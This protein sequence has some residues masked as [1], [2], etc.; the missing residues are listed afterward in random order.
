MI[1][2]KAYVNKSQNQLQALNEI[3]D[4][5]V[6]VNND[7]QNKLQDLIYESKD[8]KQTIEKLK[9]EIEAK[10]KLIEQLISD[11]NIKSDAIVKYENN[12][13]E[14]M[15]KTKDNTIQLRII[16][17]KNER[18]KKIVQ[19]QSKELERIRSEN[20]KLEFDKIAES[21]DF[22]QERMELKKTIGIAEKSISH[23]TKEKHLLELKNNLLQKK[24][25]K[26]ESKTSSKETQ[27]K[28]CY[29]TNC[30]SES[31]IVEIN[32]LLK[33]KQKEIVHA[34]KY[35][36][37][38][39]EE[40]KKMQGKHKIIQMESSELKKRLEENI[41][42]IEKLEK[43]KNNYMKENEDLKKRR[44]QATSEITRLTQ[45]ITKKNIKGRGSLKKT[46][47]QAVVEILIVGN[48]IG[49]Y[50]RICEIKYRT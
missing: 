28:E 19:K 34:N 40:L 39:L 31:D 27:T 11:I 5:N 32:S 26:S 38:I 44:E 42:K 22:S 3:N 20:E 35:A 10:K 33:Q 25:D 43:E 14:L 47:S 8:D 1:A 7:L 30:E 4:K 13:N 23:L 15:N 49:G 17:E 21:N 6:S 46:A 24:L 50:E 29:I 45:K 48:R 37:T 18:L 2:L 9:T 12:L 36:N 16:N 41:I